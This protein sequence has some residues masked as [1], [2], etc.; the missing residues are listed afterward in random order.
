ML[1][2][3]T[4]VRMRSSYTD[5]VQKPNMMLTTVLPLGKFYARSDA[6]GAASARSLIAES[7]QEAP[8]PCKIA[9][10]DSSAASHGIAGPHPNTIAPAYVHRPDSTLIMI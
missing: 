10:S 6:P 9:Q 2:E 4:P 5:K 1:P 7:Q 8:S 3:S